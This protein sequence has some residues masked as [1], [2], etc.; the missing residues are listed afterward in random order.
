MDVEVAEQVGIE[1]DRMRC[2]RC[3]HSQICD[4][5]QIKDEWNEL[6]PPDVVPSDEQWTLLPSVR[7]A[8]LW[9][10]LG[11]R[12]SCHETL[13]RIRRAYG[14][15]HRAYHGARHISACLRLVD[16]LDV[17][18]RSTRLAEVEAAIWWHDLVYDTRAK[19]NEERSAEDAIAT[20]AGARVS[21]DVVDRIASHIL[22]T[23]KHE[24]SESDG[25][26]VIDIDLSILA[27][28][29]ASYARFEEEIRRE[30]AWVDAASYAAGR[31]AVLRHF[32]ERPHVYTTP[33]FQE[34]WNA[35]ARANVERAIRS[36]APTS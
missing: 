33:F 16:D 27:E 35:R 9:S 21:D 5:Q 26:L 25:G 31:V 1:F 12:G 28:S 2:R 32:L 18:R 6:V 13:H 7:F 11:A 34:Q 24:S 10:S 14:E 36:L 4:E 20:L 29:E 30:Y 15:P 23:K 3:E 19:D 22:A 17:K 8:D